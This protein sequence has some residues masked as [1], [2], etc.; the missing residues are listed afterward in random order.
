MS[1][2]AMIVCV[3]LVTAAAGLFSVAIFSL[4]FGWRSPQSHKCH[5][6]LCSACDQIRFA[7]PPI[8]P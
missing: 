5:F 2:A 7:R 4:D 8:H 1:V 3:A 6:D